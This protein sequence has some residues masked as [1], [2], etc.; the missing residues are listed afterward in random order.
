MF[1]LIFLFILLK[2]IVIPNASHKNIL[3]ICYD[4]H[5]NILKIILT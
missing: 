1:L 5:Q 3:E 2:E 4:A